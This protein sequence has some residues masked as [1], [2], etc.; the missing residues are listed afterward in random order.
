MSAKGSIFTR[1]LICQSAKTPIS[2]LIPM[3]R[4]IG[5]VLRCDL[6]KG[7]RMQ[8]DIR[9][10]DTKNRPYVA[11]ESALIAHGLPYPVNL[12]TALEAEAAICAEAAT[13][14]TIAVID[15]VPVVGLKDDE[16]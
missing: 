9:C 4:Y 12:Q 14:A 6:K 16:I 2:C 3:S 11:L 13:P 1:S 15:G 10:Q 5:V 7:T 8:L